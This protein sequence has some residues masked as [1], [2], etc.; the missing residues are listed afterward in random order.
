MIKRY[1]YIL[2]FIIAVPVLGGCST[3]SA[4]GQQQFTAFMSPQ[5]E[6]QVGAQE[7]A[8][9]MAQ[10]GEYKNANVQ[11]YVEAVGQSVV[12]Y[13]ER[14]D[15]QYK[16]TVLDSPIVNAFALPGGYIYVTRGLLALANDEAEMASVLGHEAGHITGRHSAERY[17]RGVA[18]SLGAA[19]LSAAIGN[20]AASQALGMG[21]N[22]Y[23]TSYSRGQESEADTLG[24]R[25]LTKTGYD[26]YGMAGFLSNLRAEKNLQAQIDGEQSPENSIFSTHPPTSER[27]NKT[28]AEA[29][30]L[31]IKGAENRNQYLRVLDGMTYGDSAD[32]GFARGN[33]FYH[34]KLGFKF[35]VP[36]GFK[37]VN[38]P[39]QIVAT[40]NQGVMMVFDFAKNDGRHNPVTFL[41][42]VWM[43]GAGDQVRVNDLSAITVNGMPAAT[44]YV[45]GAVG[46]KNM[47]I[48]LVAIQF[49]DTQIARFQI[50][51]PSGL[52]SAQ[53]Q[54]VKAASYSFA[55]MSSSE[56]SGL[57]PYRIRIVTARNGD[58]VASMAQK[59]AQNDFKEQRFR[60]LNGLYNGQGVVA[61]QLYKVVVE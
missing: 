37:I 20:D 51:L 60:V 48:R 25:Y 40:S 5:Q 26:P 3:N 49:S 17:S 54:S 34:P 16:F 58:S 38:Q 44:G 18:T 52:S 33:V 1:F 23:L 39:S 46:G 22:L 14:P 32:Q 47:Q 56:K 2:A 11:N 42:D 4:T 30:S 29:R 10:F 35:S 50:G 41:R 36:D 45:N 6:L 15:V 61:G 9:V 12:R 13:T 55:R 8:K 59:M 27:V 7:H 43:A 53:M 24:I 21:A 57:K 31:N 19:I 28:T